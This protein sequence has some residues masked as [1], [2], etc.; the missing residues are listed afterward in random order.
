M[1]IQWFIIICFISLSFLAVSTVLLIR[2][3]KE[4]DYISKTKETL[5]A[6]LYSFI[7]QMEIIF[8]FYIALEGVKEIEEDPVL[9]KRFEKIREEIA[10]VRSAVMSINEFRAE[11]K[12]QD[13][14]DYKIVNLLEHQLKIVN[15]NLFVSSVNIIGTIQQF[16]ATYVNNKELLSD[17]TYTMARLIFY[18]SSIVPILSDF[19]GSSNEISKQVIM[20]MVEKFEIISNF[21][22]QITKDIQATMTGLMDENRR[23]SLAAVVKKA[24]LVVEEFENFFQDMQKLKEVSNNFVEKSV[25]KLKSIS[26]MANSIEEIAETIKIISLNVS[27]EAANTG[28]TGK[29]FQVL[30][31]DLREFAIRTRQ[32]AQDVKLR[33]RDTIVTTEKLKD[34]YLDNMNRVYEYVIGIKESLEEFAETINRSFDKI[35][36]VIQSLEM[37]SDKIETGIK[38]VVGQL[39][40]YD[41][42][43]QEVEHISVFISDILERFYSDVD[44]SKIDNILSENEKT[45]VR[46]EMIKNI[47]RLVSTSNER[48]ILQKYEI[49]YGLKSKEDVEKEVRELGSSSDDESI[50]VF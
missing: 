6:A 39:Q 7:P 2:V 13:K 40:Y 43:S 15:H 35:K 3:K 12:K 22:E 10:Q 23:D 21:S 36:A 45:A 1:P 44:Q 46:N 25:D 41:V 33:V 34:D 47:H 48:A 24:R 5:L 4:K 28:S 27:V 17:T 30:A 49:S 16:F 19:T 29:G 20:E 38:D 32:F 37:F 31:R 11:I 50:F 9:K 14:I 8:S 18:L 26:D 42:R